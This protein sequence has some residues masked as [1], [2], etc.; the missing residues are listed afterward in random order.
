[1]TGDR[2][3]KL[4]THELACASAMPPIALTATTISGGTRQTMRRTNH[5]SA[6]PKSAGEWTELVQTGL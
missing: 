2:P 1:M 4:E 5:T 6:M 3:P